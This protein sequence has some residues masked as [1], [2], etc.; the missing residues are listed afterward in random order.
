MGKSSGLVISD[1]AFKYSVLISYNRGSYININLS[2][3]NITSRKNMF[4]H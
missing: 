4:S 1:V 3:C 2:F